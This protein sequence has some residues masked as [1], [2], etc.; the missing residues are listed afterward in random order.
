LVE[1]LTALKTRVCTL[2]RTNN[3]TC[4]A[5][6]KDGLSFVERKLFCFFD[7]IH[8]KTV[9]VHFA[10]VNFVIFFAEMCIQNLPR[11][12]SIAVH[13]EIYTH[14]AVILKVFW[15]YESGVVFFKVEC[16]E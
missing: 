12:V 14:Y 7:G 10:F 5:E 2:L 1:R 9:S 15:A 6:E 13:V 3:F 16:V 4:P 11:V 8:M